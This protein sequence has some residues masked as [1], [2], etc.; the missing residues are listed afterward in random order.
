[1]TENVKPQ[2]K[3][4]ATGNDEQGNVTLSIHR[5]G[6]LPVPLTLIPS[7][8]AL[9][10]PQ[11]LKTMVKENE[12]VWAVSPKNILMLGNNASFCLNYMSPGS[13]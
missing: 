12:Q 6:V 4:N 11:R 2:C 3:V 8:P 10:P 9:Q 1:M 7:A 5:A 13:G